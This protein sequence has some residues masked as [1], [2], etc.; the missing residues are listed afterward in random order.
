VSWE[1]AICIEILQKVLSC[2]R[3]RIPAG[4]WSNPARCEPAD[5]KRHLSSSTSRLE[6]SR[7]L[8]RKNHKI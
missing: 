7:A 6:C 5:G 3:R 4:A 2:M 8:R 1:A